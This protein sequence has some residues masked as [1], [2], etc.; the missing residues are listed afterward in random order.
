M[1]KV[2]FVLVVAGLLA[3]CAES[4]FVGR[5]ELTIVTNATLPPPAVVDMISEERAYVIGPMDK[6]SVD[7]FGVPDLSR[8]VQVDAS[9]RVALPLIGVLEA[10]GKTTQE[11]GAMIEQR[12]V[13]RFVR[14]PRVT[15]N[16]IDTVSQVVTVDGAVETPGL[17]PIAGRMTLMRAIARA[18]GVTEFSRENHV[19]V[20]R[21]VNNQDM[22]ALYDLRAIRQGIYPDPPIYANDVV[23][24]SESRSRRL[25]RDL[26]A[27]SGVL[28]APII[29]I[30][31]R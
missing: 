8:Q 4:R 19:I 23:L 31:Q 6:V 27:A 15:V 5:P 11:L 17:Y 29:G 30:L 14:Q 10:S 18:E 24:V 12:L 28:T 26:L 9:G 13:G 16:L 20:F 3:G 25:F 22:A 7:V 2:G 1:K 21:R